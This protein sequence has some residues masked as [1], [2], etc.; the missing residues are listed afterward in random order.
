MNYANQL[1]QIKNK[2]TF[3]KGPES[4]KIEFKWTDTFKE[5]KWTSYSIHFE[6]YNVLFNLA[7]INYLLGLETTKD[8]K[9][10]EFVLKD[11]IKYYQFAAGFFNL[12]KEEA[13]ST[14]NKE[15]LPYDMDPNYLTYCVHICTSLAQILLIEVAIKKKSALNLQA[16]LEKGVESG[17]RNAWNLI[18]NSSFRKHMDDIWKVLIEN[19]CNYYEAKTFEK[20][21]D[22]SIEQFNK[23]GV[24]YGIAITYQGGVVLALQKNVK[25]NKKVEKIITRDDL[26]L[27]AA[28]ELGEQMYEKN[29][30]IYYHKVP[31]LEE[32]PEVTPKIMANPSLPP[33][34][35][36]KE[37][38]R[39][40]LEALVPRQV[41]IKLIFL[42]LG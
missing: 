39:P 35:S 19:R 40:E 3:G 29:N 21:R 5:S 36:T 15:E 2:M 8:A 11:G 42:N 25:S 4:V 34:F 27:P 38:Y 10:D 1:V 23:S 17:F 18:Q 9:L 13:P 41:N 7:I 24:N 26:N 12:I 20:M 31:E 30:K 32:L 6:Y 16:Q 14:I 33:E 28:Q 22:Y 37:E